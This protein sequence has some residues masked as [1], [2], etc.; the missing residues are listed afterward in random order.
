MLLAVLSIRRESKV[1][2]AVI[3]CCLFALTIASLG[4]VRSQPG[5]VKFGRPAGVEDLSQ[6]T[7][8]CIFQ[9]GKGFLWIGTQDGLNKYDGYSFTIYRH[10]QQNP[11]SLSNNSIAAIHEDRAGALWVGTTGG[12]LNRFDRESETFTAFRHDA[13][14][15][16]SISDDSVSFVHEDEAGALWVGTETGGLNKFNVQTGEFTHYRH[17]PNDSTSLSDDNVRAVYADDASALWI[18]TAYSGLEK[19]DKTSGKFAHFKLD[20]KSAPGSNY[21]ILSIAADETGALLVGSEGGGLYRLDRETGEF[22]VYRHDPND[23]GSLSGDTINTIY[24]D[25]SGALWV[26]TTNGLNKFDATNNRFIQ[27]THDPNDADALGGNAISALYEDRSG[28]LWIG[29]QGL[30]KLD[31]KSK[32]FDRFKNDARDERSLSGGGVSAFFEDSAGGLWIGTADGLNFYDRATGEFRRYRHD[33]A[34]PHSLSS[35]NVRAINEDD[36]GALLV[37]TSGGGLA[38]LNRATGRFTHFRHDVSNPRSLSD[39]K[40]WEIVKDADGALWLGTQ[41]GVSRLDSRTGEFTVYRNE[42]ANPNSLANNDVRAIL[43]DKTG[44][45]WFGTRHG[46]LDKFDSRSGRFEHYK[47]DENDPESLSA[48]AVYY[49]HEAAGGTLW[50]GTTG[51]L[52]RFDRA[53]GAFERFGE[54]DGLPNNT[55]YGIL[56]DDAGNL[57]VSTNKGIARFNPQTRQSRNYNVDD[58]LQDNEFNASAAFKSADGRMFFGGIKGFNSFYPNQ[59]ID[60][61]YKPPV[62]I[63]AFKKFDRKIDFGNAADEI[64]EVEFSYED[65]SFSVEFAALDFTAPQRNQYA[66]KLEGFDRDWTQSGTRRAAY[67]TNL[68]GGEYVFRVRGTNG[69]G[70]WSDREASVKIRIV[71][72]FWKTGWFR[73]LAV[74]LLIAAAFLIYKRRVRQ[75]ERARTLQQAFSRQLIESQERERRRIAVEL[76]DGLGQSLVVIKNRALMGLSAHENHDRLVAQIEE[77]SVAASAAISEVRGIARNLHPYQIEYLGLTTALKT[78]IEAVRDSSD[79][80][81]TYEIDELGDELSKT[82]EINVYRI[83]QEALNNT[84]KHS[85]AREAS[86]VLRKNGGVLDLTIKDDGKGFAV[87][88]DERNV[89]LGLIGIGERAR[90]I[91]ARHEIASSESGTT[92][93]LQMNLTERKS[94]T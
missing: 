13:N 30:T 51:G 65:P 16:Y 52:N 60:S 6:T 33:A 23:A 47:H 14:N 74:C 69:D 53:R 61:S 57:W 86:V 35:D 2:G 20:S 78:M 88:S 9:D 67:Y 29:A 79:I 24:T 27:Y 41:N 81:F 72:P 31:L 64:G 76:H 15:F 93:H 45:L 68:D 39:D 56:D 36:T 34:S 91:G 94:E 92:I 85:A 43:R 7:A 26:G 48:N 18:G 77:I 42:P 40:V 28:V 70:V 73:T 83:V 44:A 84:V 89:G 12:G 4:I 66:Y 80:R 17:D 90:I 54:K 75:L 32:R 3:A 71:P 19:F 87:E 58:G 62:V 50:I 49:L 38:K 82:V 11:R 8:R 10:E 21:R 5:A 59:I 55:I 63:T 46:G 1:S 22:T 25:S 37:G